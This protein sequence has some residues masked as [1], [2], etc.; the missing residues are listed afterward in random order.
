MNIE[1]K[2]LCFLRELVLAKQAYDRSRK[3]FLDSLQQPSEI[4][5]YINIGYLDACTK[6]LAKGDARELTLENLISF[7]EAIKL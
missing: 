4:N 5:G 3:E 2:Q 6:E 1:D 7:K